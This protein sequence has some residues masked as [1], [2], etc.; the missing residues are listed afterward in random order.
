VAFR[1]DL[2]GELTVWIHPTHEYS[3]NQNRV[4][5]TVYIV[6][7]VKYQ[8]LKYV[9]FLLKKSEKMRKKTAQSYLPIVAPC[10]FIPVFFYVENVSTIL[11]PAHHTDRVIVLISLPWFFCSSSSAVALDPWKNLQDPYPYR[12]LAAQPPLNSSIR[13]QPPW[14][15]SWW[16]ALIFHGVSISSAGVAR[17]PPAGQGFS[18]VLLTPPAKRLHGGQATSS[19][20]LYLS[21]GQVS[22]CRAQLAQSSLLEFF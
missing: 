6:N 19:W 14:A 20:H 17:L 18:S 8:D 15:P 13:I 10:P 5:I 4:T 11:S 21:A 12:C 1:L 9:Q 3:S 16:P 7:I 22:L 2:K